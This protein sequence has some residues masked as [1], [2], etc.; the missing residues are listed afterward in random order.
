MPLK[1][2]TLA[3]VFSTL[4]AFLAQ[5]SLPL[6][7]SPVPVTG[8]TLGVFL[9]GAILS[10]KTGTLAV[11]GYLLLG[12]VGLPVFARGGAGLAVFLGPTG[13]YLWGFVLGVYLMGLLLE[14]GG[15]DPGYFRLAAGMIL[16]QVAVYILGTLQLSYYLNLTFTRGLILAVGPYIPLDLLKLFLATIVSFRARRVLQRAGYLPAPE[17]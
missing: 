2:M 7:F 8:Q 1:S 3:A 16:C 6:P 17:R 10:K 11:F 15:P 13:G 5:L 9:A 4:I 14:K 12:A